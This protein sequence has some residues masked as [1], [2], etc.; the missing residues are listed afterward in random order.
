MKLLSSL[1][2]P[3]NLTIGNLQSSASRTTCLRNSDRRTTPT[4]N[5]SST[6]SSARASS[7]RP[8]PPPAPTARNCSEPG[9]STP[10]SWTKSIPPRARSTRRRSSWRKT[11]V[12]TGS[13]RS[14]TELAWR[15]TPE[16]A[17]DCPVGALRASLAN[18]EP[19]RYTY[20]VCFFGEASQRSNNNN[21]RT[22]LGHFKGWAPDAEAG[23]DDYYQR[24]VYAEGQRCWNGPQRSAKVRHVTSAVPA[25]ACADNRGSLAT[26]WT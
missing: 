22:S 25:A 4:S 26:R 7:I 17:S 12:V 15:R 10:T 2:N 5:R 13:G 1:S 16:S 8:C 21:V 20:S 19:H 14:W 24:Q 6:S 23:S 3:R 9:V 18:N 11:G